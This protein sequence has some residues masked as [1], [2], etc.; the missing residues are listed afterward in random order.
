MLIM[1]LHRYIATLITTLTLSALPDAA[2]SQQAE[3]T[4]RDFELGEAIGVVAN[5]MRELETGFVEP[6]SAEE[7]LDAAT[8][9]LI[10]ATDPYS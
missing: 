5:V 3:R 6:L 4:A 10:L 2:Y 1:R 7:L 9:G 8:T